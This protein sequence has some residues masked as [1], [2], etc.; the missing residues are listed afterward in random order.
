MAERRN[1][2]IADQPPRFGTANCSAVRIDDLEQAADNARVRMTLEDLDLLLQPVRQGNIVRIHSCN[3][4]CIRSPGDLVRTCHRPPVRLAFKQRYPRVLR[5]PVA[6]SL[7]RSI[8]RTVV[9]NDEL[10]V[11]KCL[12]KNA[13][14]RFVQIGEGIIYGHDNADLRRS[15]AR[16]MFRS[17]GQ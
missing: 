15:R 11:R 1:H 5:S 13:F 3:D 8:G 9:E 12:R 10:E 4:R 6:K 17:S 2:R 14:D 16:I 7:G